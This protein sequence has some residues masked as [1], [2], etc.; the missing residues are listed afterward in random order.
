[1]QLRFMAKSGS[2]SVSLVAFS[3]SFAN[4]TMAPGEKGKWRGGCR[5]VQ[6]VEELVY[7]VRWDREG[8]RWAGCNAVPFKAQAR[9]KR[10]RRLLAWQAGYRRWWIW[11]RGMR[12]GTEAGETTD[13]VA[14]LGLLNVAGALLR[15]TAYLFSS[16]PGC[17]TVMSMWVMTLLRSY[18]D[19]Y[20]R[21]PCCRVTTSSQL[22]QKLAHPTKSKF[23]PL[24]HSLAY[25]RSTLGLYSTVHVQQ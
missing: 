20:C 2:S 15:G 1:M 24:L 25:S 12:G 9:S 4:A 17:R 14:V 5:P 8:C 23:Q 21:F 11:H 13:R 22:Q 18:V 16:C 6:P 3:S 19:V 7:A 10:E